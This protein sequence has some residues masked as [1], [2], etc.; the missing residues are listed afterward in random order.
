M[1][2]KEIAQDVVES[3]VQHYFAGG[4]YAKQLWLRDKGWK[5]AQHEHNFEHL[6]FLATGTVRV[7]V[8]GVDCVYTA[9]AGVKIAAGKVH[10]IEALTD[11]CLWLCIHAVP[12]EL[13]GSLNIDDVL[14]KRPVEVVPV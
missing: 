6:S 8:D 13:A 1:S 12:A 10:E 5:V 9:P 2:N 7:T 4:V 14:V 11:N 3:A